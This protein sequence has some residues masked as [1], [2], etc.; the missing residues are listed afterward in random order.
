MNALKRHHYLL[1]Y[2]WWCHFMYQGYLWDYL[3]DSFLIDSAVRYDVKGKKYIDT[4][5]KY[6]FTD[7]DCVMPGLAF[8]NWKKLMLWKILYLMNWKYGDLM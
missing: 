5:V 4:P 2:E 7:L 3:C 6:Y 1:R 8:V